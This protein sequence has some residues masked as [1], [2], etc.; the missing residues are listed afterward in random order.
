M[1]EFKALANFTYQVTMPFL[2]CMER[3]TQHAF[4]DILPKLCKDLSERKTD[5]LAEFHVEWTHVK[6]NDNRPISDL[7]HFLLG[8]MCKQAALGVELQCKRE[9]WDDD[10]TRATPLFRLTE[11]ERAH[12]PTNN[13]SAEKYLARFGY[14]ASQSAGH[15]NWL[16]KAKRIKDGLM[17][18][19]ES[20]SKVERSVF[21]VLKAL[22]TMEVKWS[23]R[24]K[25]AKKTWQRK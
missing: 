25:E 11:E 18:T 4:I 20:A 9:Y 7:D 2:N 15:S 23:E 24:Q 10:E 19:G 16:F 14:L 5:T 21:A 8:V 12:L 22:D 17:L 13:L 6:M 3:S 1:A